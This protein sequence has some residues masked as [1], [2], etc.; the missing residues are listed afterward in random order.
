MKD[1]YFGHKEL[2]E[3]VL[4]AKNPM[5]FGSRYIEADEP[6]L[7]FDNIQISTLSEQNSPIMARGGWA[8]MPRVIWDDR[9]EVQFQLVEGVMSSVGM[10]ILLSANV[11]SEQDRQPL[12]VHM[13]E[14]PLVAYEHESTSESE[15]KVCTCVDLKYEPIIYPVKKMFIFDYE[16]NAIQNKIYGKKIDNIKDG[17]QNPVYRIE[18]YNDKNCTI[19]AKNNREYVVDYYYEYGVKENE[20]ALIYCV[21]KE[22]F[23]GLFTLEAKFY[24]KDENEGQNYTNI[25]YMPKV[26]IVSNINLRLGERADPT[27]ST[28]NIIGLPETVGDQ[29]NLI[30][31]I[32]RLNGDIDADI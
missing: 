25:V 14:G 2:Y 3:V 6:V 12:Y 27:V 5:Q 23:N 16:N 4:R 7:Y 1:Q 15:T 20:E 29:K 28:F 9:S 10:G 22:R 11:L 30:M 32:T 24:S 8:N 21:N 18:L 31:E 26:R 17:Y 13:K 19:P